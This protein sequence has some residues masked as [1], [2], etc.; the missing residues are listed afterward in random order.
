MEVSLPEVREWSQDGDKGIASPLMTMGLELL[1][2]SHTRRKAGPG[3]NPGN[4][5]MS[6]TDVDLS[7]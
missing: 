6:L 7:K 4:I 1:L 2:P 3:P 5:D